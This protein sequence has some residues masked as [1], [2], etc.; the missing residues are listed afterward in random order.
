MSRRVDVWDGVRAD[1]ALMVELQT[2][3]ADHH[4]AMAELLEEMV[5][6]FLRERQAPQRGRFEPRPGSAWERYGGGR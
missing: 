2:W 5:R 6:A 4:V 3:C 1:E